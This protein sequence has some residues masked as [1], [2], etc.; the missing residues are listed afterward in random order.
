MLPPLNTAQAL[1]QAPQVP[2]VPAP[3]AAVVYDNDFMIGASPAKSTSSF[4]VGGLL[5]R[6]RNSLSFSLASKPAASSPDPSPAPKADIA[7]QELDSV[8]DSPEKAPRRITKEEKEMDD[9]LVECFL[10]AAKT[11]V[12]D[13]DLPIMGT[14][15]YGKHMRT[16]RQVGTSCDV[17][18]SSYFGFKDFAKQLEVDGLITLNPMSADPQITKIHRDHWELREWEPWP[19]HT[20]VAAHK[21]RR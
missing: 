20:T 14:S 21:S 12:K 4:S 3:P 18:D 11:R 16:C 9:T 8:A 19:H 5:G 1:P 13:R 17:K 2:D 15:F 6:V 10:Q 7:A